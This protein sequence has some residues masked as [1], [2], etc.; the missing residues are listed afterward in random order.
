MWSCC[1]R[2]EFF[3][4]ISRLEVLNSDSSLWQIKGKSKKEK[5]IKILH[6]SNDRSNNRMIM[7]NKI[8]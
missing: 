6:E 3:A 2:F 5:K 4:Y 8:K 7:S 1:L